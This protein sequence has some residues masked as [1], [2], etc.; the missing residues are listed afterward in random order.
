MKTLYSLI[1]AATLTV[2]TQS[3]TAIEFELESGEYTNGSASLGATFDG[4]WRT[5]DGQGGWEK[6][7]ELRDHNGIN[8][9][10]DCYNECKDDVNCKGIEFQSSSHGRN[11]CEIHYDS[12]RYCEQKPSN[13]GSHGKRS[14]CWVKIFT[15]Y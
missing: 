5:E 8:N 14:T 12:F 2:S 15:D 1:I 9:W 3:A 6:N 10:N 11:Q 13:D 7:D 4:Y